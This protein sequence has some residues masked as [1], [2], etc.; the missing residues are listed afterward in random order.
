MI[1][2]R[3]S[4]TSLVHAINPHARQICKNLLL[5]NGG[6]QTGQKQCDTITL[7]RWSYLQVW[8]KW[9]SSGQYGQCEWSLGAVV[10]YIE[11]P[12]FETCRRTVEVD[13][14]AGSL[15]YII[16]KLLYIMTL[17]PTHSQAIYPIII[18]TLFYF[19]MLWW[20]LW[21]HPFW[22]GGWGVDGTLF[23]HI[24]N[25]ADTVGLFICIWFFRAYPVT[26]Y[27]QPI[28]VVWFCNVWPKLNPKYPIYR[29]AKQKNT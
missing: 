24:Y 26:L 9:T 1:S 10:I 15:P 23:V 12:S 3:S 5:I 16:F 25:A 19:Y 29:P 20:I 13:W 22:G 21:I 28:D 14:S 11:L 18:T 7:P 2:Y 6:S 8:P 17:L 4:I 27:T